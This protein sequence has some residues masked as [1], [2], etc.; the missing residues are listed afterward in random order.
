MTWFSAEVELNV[1]AICWFFN[2]KQHIRTYTGNVYYEIRKAPVVVEQVF[3]MF[4]PPIFLFLISVCPNIVFQALTTEIV[5]DGV[6]FEVGLKL[7]TAN[8]SESFK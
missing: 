7:V 2:G 8:F 4:F 1:R 5:G 6:V 3:H